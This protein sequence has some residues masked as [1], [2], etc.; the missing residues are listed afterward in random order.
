VSEIGERELEAWRGA[1]QSERDRRPPIPAELRRLVARERRKLVLTVTLEALL[2]VGSLLGVGVAVRRHPDALTWT[3]AGAVVVLFAGGIAFA[4]WN[5]RGLLDPEGETCEK[6]LALARARC[7]S[8]IRSVRFVYW[9]LAVEVVFLLA[10]GGWEASVKHAAMAA[11]P[12]PY[13]VRWTLTVVAIAVALAWARATR[14]RVQ[15]QSEE[16]ARLASEAG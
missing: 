13:V 4:W 11:D 2:V 5:R 9:L 1:W 8:R 3:W 15:R 16:L 14:R 7:A 12:W 10:W 6:Y